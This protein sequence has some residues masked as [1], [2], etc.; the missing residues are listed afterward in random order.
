MNQCKPIICGLRNQGRERI[1]NKWIPKLY[2]RGYGVSL[3][4]MMRKANK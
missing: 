2:K 3:V 1:S 4:S